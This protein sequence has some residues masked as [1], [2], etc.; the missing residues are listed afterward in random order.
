ME[1]E[2]RSGS[3]KKILADS[4]FLEQWNHRGR[5]ESLALTDSHMGFMLPFP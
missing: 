3:H 1:S 4:L 5:K 2:V